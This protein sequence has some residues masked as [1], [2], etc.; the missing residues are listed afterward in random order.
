MRGEMTLLLHLLHRADAAS[1]FSGQLLLR[2][3]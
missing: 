2:K 1:Q 3:S